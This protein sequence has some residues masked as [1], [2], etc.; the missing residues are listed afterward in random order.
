MQHWGEGHILLLLI[1][2]R[3]NLAP[4]SIKVQHRF[5]AFLL[6]YSTEGF[7]GSPARRWSPM[8]AS[9]EGRRH[10]ACVIGRGAAIGERRRTPTGVA[11]GTRWM[12]A[13]AGW[14]GRW[15][16]TSV[17]GPA[18]AWRRQPADC[19]GESVGGPWRHGGADRRAAGGPAAGGR[20]QDLVGSSNV[21]WSDCRSRQRHGRA[22]GLG[23]MCGR[24]SG[25]PI[26][27]KSP[28]FRRPAPSRCLLP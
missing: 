12:A 19:G 8:E 4:K 5:L 22:S 25:S 14:I 9:G 11:D 26:G 28:Y 7:H 15:R 3:Q 24:A 6:S 27:V 17:Q 18:A 23:A 2:L 16:R 10:R 21:G 13:A 1:F 20:R